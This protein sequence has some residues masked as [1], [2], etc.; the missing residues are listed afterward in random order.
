MV[1]GRSGGLRKVL[2]ANVRRLRS[3]R[4]LSQ[5][6]FADDC[7][8]HRTQIGAVER[9]ETNLTID[10]LERIALALGVEPKRLLARLET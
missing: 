10:N 1:A 7:G 9:G 6:A 8:L 5:E 2:G 3:A 4:G